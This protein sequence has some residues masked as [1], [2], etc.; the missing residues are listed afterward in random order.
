VVTGDDD[1][2]VTVRA[3]R[4]VAQML[5]LRVEAVREMPEPGTLVKKNYKNN[6]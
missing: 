3:S 1:I 2:V 6:Q 5:V 4:R